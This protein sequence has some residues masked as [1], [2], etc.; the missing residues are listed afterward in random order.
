MASRRVSTP[1]H[2]PDGLQFRSRS[3]FAFAVF[4]VHRNGESHDK[5][6]SG[7]H[8]SDAGDDHGRQ[9]GDRQQGHRIRPSA[10]YGNGTAFRCGIPLLPASDATHPI[11]A[12]ETVAPR[13]AHP[14][15]AGRGG[16]RRLYDVVDLRPAADVGDECRRHHRHAAGRLGGDLDPHS[17]RKAAPLPAGCHR[18]C[19]FRRLLGRGDTGRIRRGL[20][21]RQCADPR[22]RHLRGAVHS[23]QQAHAERRSCR[24]R[25]RR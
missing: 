10:V 7:L 3:Y 12:A 25:S 21:G 8:L 5:S 24:S 20:P 15:D 4:F 14:R 16:Q 13:L 19:C 18:A 2:L 1:R 22:R 17:R 6:I 23:S 11:A 9:H